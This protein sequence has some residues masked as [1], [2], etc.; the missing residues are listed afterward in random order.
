MSANSFLIREIQKKDNP[1]IEQVIRACFPEF[2]IPLK[3][4]AFEDV[5]TSNLFDAYQNENEVYY[6]IEVNGKVEGGGGIKQLANYKAGV[7]ELQKMYFSPTIRGKGYGKIM[8]QK[9]LEKAK[10]FGFEQCYLET[11]PQLKSAIYLY[12]NFGFKNLNAALGNTCHTSCS[13]WMLKNL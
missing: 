6:V 8:I 9:C 5:E 1:E 12:Q 13:I 2:K 11:A 4:T 7:C 3:G 10:S